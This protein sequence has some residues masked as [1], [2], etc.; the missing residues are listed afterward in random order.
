MQTSQLYTGAIGLGVIVLI[1][2]ILLVAGIF[3][4]HHTLPYIVLVV[5]AILVI[6]GIVGMAT[7][8]RRRL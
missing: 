4:T 6:I 8:R 1:I 3:G 7:T 5:G 2:G